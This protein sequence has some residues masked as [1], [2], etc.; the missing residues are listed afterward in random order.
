MKRFISLFVILI[1]SI[2]TIY[3]QTTFT[4]EAPSSVAVGQKFKVAF[5]LSNG[6]GE[7]IK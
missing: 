7:D 1:F 4:V 5:I 2:I 6:K 3:S